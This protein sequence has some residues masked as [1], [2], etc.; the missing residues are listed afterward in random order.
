M[1]TNKILFIDET[2]AQVT[3]AFYKQAHIFGTPEYKLWRAYLA[4]FPNAQMVTKTIKKNPDK[5]TYKNHTYANMEKYIRQMKPELLPEFRKQ[6]ECSRIQTSPYRAVL[7][8]FLQQ[9]SDYDSYKQ[10]FEMEKEKERQG[11]AQ[12]GSQDGHEDEKLFLAA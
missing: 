3:K 12:Q 7:A 9:F 4:D 5:H 11:E 10:F 2:H 8:W 6:K 1:T